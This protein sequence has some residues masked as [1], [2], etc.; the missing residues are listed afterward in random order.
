VTVRDQVLNAME[1]AI[2]DNLV[3][4]HDAHYCAVAALL[5]LEAAGV[6]LMPKE[7][8]AEIKDALARCAEK[9]TPEGGDAWKATAWNG[10]LLYRAAIAASPYASPDPSP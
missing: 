1:K 4:E 3:G 9:I 8:D 7:P 6:V 10:L 2:R 5:A